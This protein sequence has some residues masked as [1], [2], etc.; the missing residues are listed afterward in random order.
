M[1]SALLLVS[2]LQAALLAAFENSPSRHSGALGCLG[3]LLLCLLSFFILQARSYLRGSGKG[4]ANITNVRS[5]GKTIVNSSKPD[6][7]DPDSQGGV[8]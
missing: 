7:D 8:T 4:P 1:F 2:N 6:K 3:L 5:T